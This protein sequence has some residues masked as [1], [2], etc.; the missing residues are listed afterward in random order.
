MA[1]WAVKKR[2]VNPARKRKKNRAKLS[3]AQIKFFGSPQQK[4]ALKRKRR[5]AALLT[6]KVKKTKK[7]VSAPVKRM[8]RRRNIPGAI[9]TAG[10]ASLNPAAKKER[11]KTMSKSKTKK[12]RSAARPNTSHRSTRRRPRRRN[13]LIPYNFMGQRRHKKAKRRANPSLRTG[14]GGLLKN[15]LFML[16]GLVGSRLLPQAFLAAK[17]TGVMGY[18]ANLAIALGGGVAIKSILKDSQAGNMFILGGIGGII[19]RA[20]QD[21]TP[22]G[23]AINSSL[24]G[25]G[26]VGI[27]GATT[28]FVPLAEAGGSDRGQM[29]LPSAVQRPAMTQPPP[30]GAGVGGRFGRG[31]FN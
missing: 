1:T 13:G 16:A 22:F 30:S 9:I 27:Y 8:K 10:L 7:R 20:I 2:L 11:R 14:G 19:L 28:F 29:D 25:V 12:R 15:G 3:P 18:G 23:Q 17:N 24:Q 5:N 26:D 21:F 4:A 31:R 6:K